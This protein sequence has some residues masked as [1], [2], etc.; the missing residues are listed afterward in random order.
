MACWA[1][2][3]DSP[4]LLPFSSVTGMPYFNSLLGGGRRLLSSVESSG[5]AAKEILPLSHEGNVDA[6]RSGDG[7]KGHEAAD[8]GR[9]ALREV[10]AH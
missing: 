7:G 3:T 8:D 6:V 9:E 5:A 4:N 10:Q 1:A 2:L